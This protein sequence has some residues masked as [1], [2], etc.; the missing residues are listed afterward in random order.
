M[1]FV[2]QWLCNCFFVLT[3]FCH[4]VRGTARLPMVFGFTFYH[5]SFYCFLLES[6]HRKIVVMLTFLNVEQHS[7]FEP[8]HDKTSKIVVRLAKTQISLGIRPD[9]SESS[10]SVWGKL[11][12]LATHQAHRSDWTDAQAEMS[13]LWAHIILLF[14]SCRG[15]NV[16][17][18]SLMLAYPTMDYWLEQLTIIYFTLIW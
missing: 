17:S 3:L 13:L 11:G 14:L 9:W 7:C 18:L 12:S 2:I 6:H 4:F 10:L 5:S 1:C 16:C 15:S 8:R